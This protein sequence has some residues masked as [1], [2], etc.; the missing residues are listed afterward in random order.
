MKLHFLGILG[1]CTTLFSCGPD[2]VKIHYNGAFASDNKVVLDNVRPL[3]RET[4][5]KFDLLTLSIGE[6]SMTINGGSPLQFKITGEGILNIGQQDF[7]IYRSRYAAPNEKFATSFGIPVSIV[8]DS[9]IVGAGPPVLDDQWFRANA[10]D[11]QTYNPSDKAAD[12]IKVPKTTL[13]IQKSWESDHHLPS[14][15][16]IQ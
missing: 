8:I 11:A 6:H 3:K 4:G 10:R 7:I 16:A 9:L 1:I 13:F 14:T 12:L 2:N 5:H 15:L